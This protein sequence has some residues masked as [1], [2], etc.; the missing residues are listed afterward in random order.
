MVCLR[1]TVILPCMME[2]INKYIAE[3]GICTGAV[4]SGT[5]FI[6]RSSMHMPF[7]E[8]KKQKEW[9][10]YPLE[11]CGMS[12]GGHRRW[13]ATYSYCGFGR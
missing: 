6:G 3:K 13:P 2:S 8:G 5:G 12:E 9:Y 4:V 1:H 7:P 10:D 11:L